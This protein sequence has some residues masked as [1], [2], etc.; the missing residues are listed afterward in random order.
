MNCRLFSE[1]LNPSIMC[2][3]C[4]IGITSTLLYCR[5]IDIKKELK[6]IIKIIRALPQ[7]IYEWRRMGLHKKWVLFYILGDDESTSRREIPRFITYQSQHTKALP[8]PLPLS[9]F[10][11]CKWSLNSGHVLYLSYR[12]VEKMNKKPWVNEDV[13]WRRFFH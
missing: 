6:K 2:Q 5:T 4:S 8:P 1:I 12:T 7:K 13:F 11:G 3:E 9:L 10:L